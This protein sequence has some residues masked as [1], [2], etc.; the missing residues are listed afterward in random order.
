MSTPTK[1]VVQFYHNNKWNAVILPNGE[2][3]SIASFSKI[4]NEE[5]GKLWADATN[6]YTQTG[7]T[8]SELAQQRDQLLAVLKDLAEMYVSAVDF[9]FKGGFK[10]EDHPTYLS[11]LNAI[12]NTTKKSGQ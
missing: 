11:A 2:Y 6:V 8:P 5:D 7:F 10:P 1:S 4:E 12:E 9:G 3:Q